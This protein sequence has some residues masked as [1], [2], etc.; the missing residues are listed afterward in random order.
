MA[1]KEKAHMN[2]LLIIGL[3]GATFEL[4]KPWVLEGKLPHLGKLLESGAHGPLKSTIPP[5]SPPAWTSFM[6]GKNP[7]KHGVF[8]FTARKPYSYEIEFVN[9]RWRRA[10]TIWKIMSDAGK[11]VC[12]LS[13]PITYPPEKVNGIMI[14]GIDTPATG[15]IADATAFHPPE[16]HHEIATKLGGYLISPNLKA[17]A[18]HQCEAMVEAAL[19]TVERKMDTALYLLAKE[20][21]DC[22]M[23]TIGETDGIAHRL[24]KYHDKHSPLS[25][26]H[27]S[28]YAG[29]DPILSI[30]QKV[31]QYIGELRTM[32]SDEI[33]MMIMSDHGHGGNGS[34]AIFLNAWLEARGLLRFRTNTNGK[35]LP[36]VV[37]AAKNIGIKVVPSSLKR[38][39][40]RKT[41]LANKIESSVRFALIDWG[42]THAYSEETPY[43][44]SVWV[45]LRGREPDGIVMPGKEYEE[46]R[47]EIIDALG[48]WS[49]PE[50]GQRYVRKVHKR[51][52]I[53]CG[54]LVEKFPDLIIEW[55]CDNGYS[56]LFK[57]SYSAKRQRTPMR[58]L[59]AK[60]RQHVK[61]GDHRDHG[62][63]MV[64]GIDIQQPMQLS[65]V[66]IID[67]APTILHML[68]LPVP[69]D[70]DGRVLTELFKA[71]SR[72]SRPVS[73][74]D[75]SQPQ[76][77]LSALR[78]DYTEDEEEAIRVRLQ[79]L[80]YIE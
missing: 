74:A 1:R 78:R 79:G 33:T 52:D 46:V 67:L 51:E 43:Y 37:D 60:E 80:G 53:Y 72:G 25:D 30:Y 5:M 55:N 26:K 47:D 50:T 57:N 71:K 7:G 49:D 21:W 44:P 66:A 63:L 10:E 27:S 31:D 54:A 61:S 59:D 24:W 28:Q 23:I 48:K 36:S 18:D 19:R 16:L 75:R 56:Y 20:P 62:I 22:F 9:A 40:F 32:A 6:T 41:Q 73:Y 14:S 29:S 45:N 64:S 38:M 58:Q 77:D 42:H 76:G 15:G 8:D 35:I 65:D 34:R 11:R 13:V 3:D 17:F 2:R 68:G 4:I 69:V 70:M 12:V 39:I